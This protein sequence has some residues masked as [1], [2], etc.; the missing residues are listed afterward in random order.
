MKTSKILKQVTYHALLVC[1]II[2]GVRLLAYGMFETDW[3]DF[4]VFY[5]SA[6]AAL[7]G[8][9]IYIITGKYN[10]PF[11]Y[12]PWAAWFYIPFAVLPLEIARTIYKGISVLAAILII[13]SLTRYYNPNF[14]FQDKILI[15]ALLVPMTLQLMIVGQMDYI[16][17]GL[18]VIIMYA[19]EQKKDILVGVLLPLLWIKPHLVIVFTL[20]VFWLAGKR[21]ILI[22]FA[23]SAFM[24]LIQTIIS[25][26]WISEML[27]L[28]QG[29]TQR[30]TSV[31]FTT[32][33]NLLGSQENWVGTANLPFTILLV[34]LAILI[35]WKFRSLPTVPL[36]SLALTA[37]L[38]CAPRSHAYDLTLLIP[39]MIWLTAKNFKSTYWIWIA[40]ALIPV[41]TVYLPPAYLLT[42]FVFILS[43]QKAYHSLHPPN[44]PE[45]TEANVPS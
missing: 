13:N 11:W 17:L 41:L 45:M 16:L 21:T 35:V 24:L 7:E 25:P 5:N 28:L 22:S 40:G 19:V 33:P 14:K 29:G 9:S 15:F 23:L 2:L 26:G 38:F 37:S 32:F 1:A 44:S 43:V 20:C 3:H 39:G 30:T 18:I 36:L 12:L 10:L 27:A 4:D 34:I 6:R 42:L 8:K 31:G